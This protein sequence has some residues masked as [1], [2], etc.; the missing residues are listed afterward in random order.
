MKLLDHFGA[1]SSLDV[2]PWSRSNLRHGPTAFINCSLFAVAG[3]SPFILDRS[4]CV[5]CG[6]HAANWLSTVRIIDSDLIS[7]HSF[8][9]ASAWA[10][11]LRTWV[12]M[13]TMP[14]DLLPR[15]WPASL[16]LVSVSHGSSSSVQ[17]V[18]GPFILYVDVCRGPPLAE[19]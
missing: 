2:Q 11:P 5:E 9:L 10:G 4:L 18:P 1:V 8:P 13:N 12:R 14:N 17:L 16:A 7:Q 3:F 15:R 19:P 6:L